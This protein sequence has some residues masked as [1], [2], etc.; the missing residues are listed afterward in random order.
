MNDRPIVVDPVDGRLEPA[1]SRLGDFLIRLAM[2]LFGILQVA[3]ILRI[4][5]LLLG[6]DQAN[7]IVRDVI[8]GTNVFVDP[9]RG[10]FKLNDVPTA[11]GSFLDVAAVIALIGWSI[12][13]AIVVAI[14]G[15]FD[16]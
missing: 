7:V 8:N 9:F 13:E 4:A 3:L 12:V 14:L 10:M 5:F 11:P 2:L 6:A 16:R 1:G 15:L